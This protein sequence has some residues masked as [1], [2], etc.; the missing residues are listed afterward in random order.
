M[1]E[2]PNILT[3]SEDLA[4]AEAP[5]PLPVGTYRGT[6]HHV[7][8]K[9]GKTS[10]KPVIHISY[11]ISPDQFPADYT[12]GNPD[13]EILTTYVSADDTPRNRYQ[14]RRLCEHHGVAPSRQIDVTGFLGQDVT[15]QVTHETYNGEDRARATVIG[16][17]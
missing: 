3:F 10:G 17:A 14:L 4:N 5:A 6:V 12:H 11:R 13:G 16:P 15:L 2:L 8:T 9:A 7:E 1:S